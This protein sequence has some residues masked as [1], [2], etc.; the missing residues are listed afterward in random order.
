VVTMTAFIAVRDGLVRSTVVKILS[1]VADTVMTLSWKVVQG[2]IP[3]S[4]LMTDTATAS[5]TAKRI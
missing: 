5:E 3:T 1:K 4:P 2:G